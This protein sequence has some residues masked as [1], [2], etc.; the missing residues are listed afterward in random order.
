MPDDAQLI[1]ATL[2]GDREAFGALVVR[3]QDRL[4]TAMKLIIGCREEAEDVVQDA[5][6]QAFVHLARFE[7]KS[8]FYTWLYRIA[9]NIRCSRAR[10]K[11]PK[12]MG[13]QATDLAAQQADEGPTA[14][15]RAIEAERRERLQEALH[16]L[17]DEYREIL[18]LRELEQHDYE[19]IAS[20]LDIRMGTVRSRLH[21]ARSQLQ[22]VL[23]SRFS[24]L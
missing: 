13:Q 22:T 3:Y 15:Q 5:F 8:Q 23:Q 11:R 24:E 1:D 14:A 12:P 18:V 7:K 10:R 6:V 21:R 4:F 16:E 17:S 19:T 20:I 2:T 9:H